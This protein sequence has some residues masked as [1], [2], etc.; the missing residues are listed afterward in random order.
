[1][2]KFVAS[3]TV[4]C[5]DPGPI[6]GQWGAWSTMSACSAVCG[7]GQQVKFREQVFKN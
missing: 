7:I 3:L 5:F 2:D 1:M 6:D 4:R